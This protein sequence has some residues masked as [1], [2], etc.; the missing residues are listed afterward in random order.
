MSGSIAEDSLSDGF[1]SDVLEGLDIA[2]FERISSSRFRPIGRLPLWFKSFY[3]PVEH[4]QYDLAMQSAFL[5]NFLIDA[6]AYWES[7]SDKRSGSRLASG[8]WSEG[9]ET[10]ARPLEAFALVAARRSL[11]AIVDLSSNF[12][13]QRQ[14]YQRARELALGQEKLALELSQKQRE[15]QAALEQRVLNQE[16]LEVI[17]NTVAGN[18]SAVLICD[19]MGRMQVANKALVDIFHIESGAS[20]QRRSVLERWLQEAEGAYPEIKRVVTSGA[21][22]EGEFESQGITGEKKW[23]RLNIGPVLDSEGTVSHYICI[24]N[25]V[26]DVHYGNHGQERF[27]DVD[28][29]TQLP[30]RHSFW[31]K[32]TQL[33]EQATTQHQQLALYYVDL[34]HFKRVNDSL[35]HH[36]GDFL[37]NT[38]AARIAHCVKRTDI[39]AHLGGDEFAVV[40]QVKQL[41]NIE[42]I[43]QRLLD[44]FIPPVTIDSTD[45]RLSASIGVAL[46]PAD[47]LDATT[48]M[49]HAD[50][51]MFHAKELGRNQCR[52]FKPA[53]GARFLNRLNLENDLEA[54]IQRGQFELYYQPQICLAEETFVRLEALIRWRHPEQG[55][56]SPA[57]FI[58]LA[59]ESELIHKI[60]L[61]VLNTACA[62]AQQFAGQGIKVVV[63]VNVSA[64][65]ARRKDFIDIVEQALQDS[66]LPPEQLEIEI[67]ETSFLE[68]MD[69][70][71]T[72]L[73]KLR[74][75]GI[76]V[77]LDDFGSGFSS[78]TYL[79]SLPVDNLKLDQTFVRELPDHEES[80]AITASVIRL[81]HD[82][83]MNV[84]AEGVET[85][86]QLDYLRQQ[87]CDYVQG[88][89]F[90]RPLPGDE[91]PPIFDQIMEAGSI[92]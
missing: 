72:M 48:L 66:G 71:V 89:Y 45:F 68:Q 73:S 54:A 57:I 49:K 37:L 27:E 56:I 1:F 5:E 21:Y 13:D 46:F 81:A 9:G 41:G 14:V 70:V 47:G 16:P 84:I 61:W 40:A 83:K 11:L 64:C 76:N 2:L 80:R 25:D 4:Q 31:R 15:L 24:A 22:W 75:M 90:Y 92:I 62:Y 8:V 55:F 36:A 35:G 51:A 3:S 67:T 82:L 91:L 58:P 77:S 63:A 86:E 65:Q 43:A 30:N 44:S 12:E 23:I 87:G 26:T 88:Y 19:A 85:V 39:V 42:T 28:P 52:F 59:E 17:A 7:P 34:D 74:R 79:K 33:I 6:E 29:V 60:G 50:L 32:I 38:F 10:V 78:L 69:E 53:I 20:G 18:A